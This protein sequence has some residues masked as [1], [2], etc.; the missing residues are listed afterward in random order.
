MM[1]CTFGSYFETFAVGAG[2]GAAAISILY[3]YIA[4]P[5]RKKK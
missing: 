5:R 1:V 4:L 3:L 2:L